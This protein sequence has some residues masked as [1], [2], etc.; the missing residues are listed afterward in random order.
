MDRSAGNPDWLAVGSFD[1][2]ITVYSLSGAGVEGDVS[3]SPMQSPKLAESFGMSGADF[4]TAQARKM[5]ISSQ[6]QTD[7]TRAIVLAHVRRRFI[8][9]D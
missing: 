8:D 6:P 4:T 9:L 5:S 1:A 3:T 2:R 7:T